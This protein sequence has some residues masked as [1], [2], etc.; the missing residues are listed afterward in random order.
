[1]AETFSG[2]WT[3]EVLQKDAAFSERFIIQGS[4]ASDGTYAGETATPPLLVSGPKWTIQF[5]WND[6]AGSGWQPSEVR[7]TD[8]AYSRQEGLIV[9]LGV[10]D[11]SAALRDRDFND[12][13]LLCRNVE[14]QLNPWY[15]VDY[16]YDFT[17][18]DEVKRRK[19]E[20]GGSGKDEPEGSGGRDRPRKRKKQCCCCCC[21]CRGS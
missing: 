17:V 14:P 10:D 3:I 8:A 16:P 19:H 2:E 1:M 7:R 6:D 18:P 21:N 11:N 13:V 9:I 5:E 4:L 15:L 20:P 12:V